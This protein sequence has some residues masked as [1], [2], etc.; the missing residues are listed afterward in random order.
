VNHESKIIIVVARLLPVAC[1]FLVRDC[2]APDVPIS[3]F[4]AAVSAE[5]S[6]SDSFHARARGLAIHPQ[7]EIQIENDGIASG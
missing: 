1:Y 4:S 6:I 3:P 5:V 7:S 2:T